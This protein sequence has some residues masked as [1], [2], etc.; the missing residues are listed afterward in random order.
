MKFR[1]YLV[2]TDSASN[3]KSVSTVIDPLKNFKRAVFVD[4][5]RRGAERKA[6]ALVVKRTKRGLK[7]TR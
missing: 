2:L 6:I 4:D 3:G 5:S 7:P 1:G